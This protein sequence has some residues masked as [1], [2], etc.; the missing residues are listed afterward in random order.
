MLHIISAAD[1]KAVLIVQELLVRRGV[2]IWYAEQLCCP[3][4]VKH[5]CHHPTKALLALQEVAGRTLDT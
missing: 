3:S 2:H 1:E 4:R 5:K